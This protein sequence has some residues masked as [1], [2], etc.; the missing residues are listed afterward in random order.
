[1]CLLQA[2]FTLALIDSLSFLGVD[3]L[4]EWLP[5]TVNLIN[6][7]SNSGLR[8]TCADRFWEV[9]SNGEMDVDR[10][11][12][13][14]EW[15]STWGGRELIIYGAESASGPLQTADESG[16]YMSGAVGRVAPESKL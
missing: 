9:L 4:K 1:M 10:A 11:H 15:W 16:P 5:L 3:D 13:C 12:F 8:Q 14:V 7:I 2:V 6:I